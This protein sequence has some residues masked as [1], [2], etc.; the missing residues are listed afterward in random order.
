ML[1]KNELIDKIEA[2]EIINNFHYH[3][4]VKNNNLS[5]ISVSK[6]N[7]IIVIMNSHKYF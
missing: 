1:K 3:S 7:F 2:F 4:H 5:L 6:L